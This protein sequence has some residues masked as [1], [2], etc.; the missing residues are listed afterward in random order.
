MSI[1]GAGGADASPEIGTSGIA[2]AGDS[3]TCSRVEPNKS[4]R[5]GIEGT[6]AVVVSM[7][8]STGEGEADGRGTFAMV[9]R[10]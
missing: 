4:A 6:V 5:S 9:G 3:T 1:C 2:G 10:S 7:S 8:D